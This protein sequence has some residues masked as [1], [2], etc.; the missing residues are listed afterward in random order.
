MTNG[1]IDIGKAG[2]GTLNVTGGTVTVQQLLATNGLNSVI[3]FN[4]GTI[5]SEDT[6]VDNGAAFM[7][8]DTGSGA[9]FIANGGTH[10]F[11]NG[12]IVGFSG[13]S[14]SLTITNGATVAS[15]FG[16]LACEWRRSNNTVLVA[17]AGSVWTEQRLP[18]LSATKAVPTAW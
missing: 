3:T 16:T 7:I 1:Q 18:L 2:S 14:N 8:G 4:G 12:M 11:T 15:A 9:T 6:T 13:S 10:D 5:I 17:G